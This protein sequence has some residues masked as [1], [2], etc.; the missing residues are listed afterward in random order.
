MRPQARRPLS[1]QNT[2]LN[3]G[4][5]HR[6]DYWLLIFSAILLATGLVVVY[7]ISPA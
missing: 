2:E 7:A 1:R 4:R 6:P 5:Q 3:L